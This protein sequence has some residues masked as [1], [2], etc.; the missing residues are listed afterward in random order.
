MLSITVNDNS[1]SPTPTQIVDKVST[2]NSTPSKPKYFPCFKNFNIGLC[3]S[4]GGA[5]FLLSDT[6]GCAVSVSVINNSVG[7]ELRHYP[8]TS[9]SLKGRDLFVSLRASTRSNVS[10]GIGMSESYWISPVFGA[11]YNLLDKT[12]KPFFSWGFYI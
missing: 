2:N 8:H 3:S 9:H 4:S 11:K 5:E 7:L 6:I 12:V 10:L 1:Q